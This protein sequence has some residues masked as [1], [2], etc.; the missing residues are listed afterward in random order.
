V[1]LAHVQRIAETV[2][3]EGYLLY[4]YRRSSTK[5]RHRWTFGG[6]APRAASGAEGWQMRT[7][8]LCRGENPWLE[9]RVRFLH[10]V[11]HECAAG[12]PYGPW[13]QAVE[14]EVCL[15]SAAV[16][17]LTA[18]PARTAFAF[19]GDAVEGRQEAVEGA[20]EQSAARLGEG[21]FR[22]TVRIENL[23]DMPEAA[24]AAD[25]TAMGRGGA[26]RPFDQALA[27]SLLATHTLLGVAG[28]AFVSAIDPPEDLRA[29]A[30]QCRC[31]GTWPVLA[32]PPGTTDTVL[33]SPI[34]LY[35]HPEIAPESPG[36]LFDGTEIDEIL[37][38]RILTLTEDEKREM[39]ADPRAAGL[40]ART[41]SLAVHDRA[42]LHGAMRRLEPAARRELRAG[43]RV[44]LMPRAPR[45]DIFDLA[46]AG[47]TAT[48]ESIEHDFEGRVFVSVTVDDDPG[49]DFG[50]EGKP[51]HRF[52]FGVGEV[53]P[54]A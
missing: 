29:E 31:L 37:T 32:G 51:G 26:G 24:P 50:S 10:L 36:D 35:D 5:N 52:Y 27:R 42:R 6:L 23:S 19:P 48:V 20:V 16:A 34:I 43:T 3:Y 22:I 49:R 1:N 40:L 14:R 44:R 39:R 11:E 54:L 30:G 38:L 45:S 46:L 33:S 41:E 12:D 53:E 17:E 47:K 9:T 21:L 15:P 8:I 7:E 18:R 2:L 13:Q 28:G 25:E 4:P